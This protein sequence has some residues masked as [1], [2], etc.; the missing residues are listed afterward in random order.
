[1][2][3]TLS[4]SGATFKLSELDIGREQLLMYDRAAVFWQMLYRIFFPVSDGAAAARRGT[5]T[6][7]GR[8]AGDEKPGG[9]GVGS[10]RE[11]RCS[12]ASCVCSQ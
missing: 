10:W 9:R 5:R 4:Y 7:E 1:M 12:A 8:E 6:L 11:F 2:S 3:R